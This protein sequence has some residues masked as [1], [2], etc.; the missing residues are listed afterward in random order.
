ML[1]LCD[2]SNLLFEYSFYLP[3][4]DALFSN[5]FE[6]LLLLRPLYDRANIIMMFPNTH[7]ILCLCYSLYGCQLCCTMIQYFVHNLRV[8]FSDSFWHL[9]NEPRCFVIYN[10]PTFDAV[11][12]KLILSSW[13]SLGKSD[14]AIT[15]SFLQSVWICWQ[16][17]MRWRSLLFWLS[18][19]FL[20]DYIFVKDS[21]LIL[22]RIKMKKIIIASPVL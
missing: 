12:R 16:L 1:G 2:P 7:C 13:S 22:S 5:Y 6:D 9:L 14:N 8:A 20:V 18:L 17:F 15:C 10:V 19:L 4:S 21:C 3:R 11:M